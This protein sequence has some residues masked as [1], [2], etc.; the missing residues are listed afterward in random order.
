MPDHIFD[1]KLLE[2]DFAIAISTGPEQPFTQV[3]E[4]FAD[5]V[6]QEANLLNGR[7]ASQKAGSH[8]PVHILDPVMQNCEVMRKRIEAL[9]EKLK[10]G[11]HES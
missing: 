1:T 10:K 9:E 11:Q 5:A 6:V 3:N 4:I 7:P 8:D 2:N